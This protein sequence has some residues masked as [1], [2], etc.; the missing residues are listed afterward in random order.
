[1][2]SLVMITYQQ[3]VQDH[4][5]AAV[6]ADAER[7]LPTSGRMPLCTWRVRVLAAPLPLQDPGMYSCI[8]MPTQ[9]ND[10]HLVNDQMH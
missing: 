7:L 10:W 5:S 3:L 2:I 4:H 6:V 8:S 1:M 9:Y